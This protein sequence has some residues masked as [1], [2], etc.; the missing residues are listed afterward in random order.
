MIEFESTEE[1]DGYEKI[2]VRKGFDKYLLTDTQRIPVT[3]DYTNI[4]TYL[5]PVSNVESDELE[6]IMPYYSKSDLIIS[7]TVIEN[8]NISLK[9]KEKQIYINGIRFSLK[10]YKDLGDSY[11]SAPDENDNGVEFEVLRS[12]VILD[13]KNRA[14]PWRHVVFPDQMHFQ[15]TQD[16][17]TNSP[18]FSYDYHY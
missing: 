9:I 12:K 11:N 13:T 6:Y 10:D 17:S 7:N 2:A 14:I 16:H 4:Y 1:L 8:N 5:T 3:E 15:K 18:C